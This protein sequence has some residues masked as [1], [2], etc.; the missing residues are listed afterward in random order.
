M[1]ARET[2]IALKSIQLQT[3][4]GLLWS[5]GAHVLFFL[6]LML[7]Q[8]IVIQEPALT[9]ISWIEPVKAAPIEQP[10]AIVKGEA[11]AAKEI[12][13]PRP[14]PLKRVEKFQRNKPTSD[15]EPDPQKARAV[16]DIMNARLA[17]LQ[18]KTSKNPVDVAALSTPSPVGRPTRAGVQ[19]EKATRPVD[20]KRTGKPS[21]NPIALTRTD[22]VRVQ[23]AGITTN[24]LVDAKIDRARP[25]DEDME[26]RR[27]LAGAQMAG[28]VADREIISY[29]KPEYPEWAKLEAVEGS[30]TIYFVV[31]PDGRVKRNVMVEKTSGFADFDNNAIE[32]IRKWQF[33]PLGSG[34]AEQWGR[35]IFHY[36]LSD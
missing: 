36:R 35:I 17:S 20:L 8:H 18:K 6:W 23:K 1:D 11:D 16:E 28:P 29:A 24:P 9:E 26:I 12:D 15:V 13:T 2:T 21:P 25:D 30:V 22:Q 5:I 31:V 27:T 34:G 4:K 33:E 3:R 10:P 14:I 19:T 7:F 32:A